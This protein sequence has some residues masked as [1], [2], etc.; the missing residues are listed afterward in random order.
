MG[1]LSIV[2]GAL[3]NF[4]PTN[5]V[6]AGG[7]ASVLVYMAGCALVAAGIAI[8]IVGP[9][10]MSMVAIAAPLAGHAVTSLVPDSVNQNLNALA[11]KLKTNVDNLK[12]VIPQVQALYPSGKN[13]AT[14]VTPITPNNIVR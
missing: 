8:P 12:A 6:I 10:T 13:G 3:K 1:A 7:A 2:A 9:V 11:A 5:S 14:N 4:Q